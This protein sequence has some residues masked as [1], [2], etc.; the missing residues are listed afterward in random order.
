MCLWL[1]WFLL[2]LRLIFVLQ[3]WSLSWN[4]L[5]VSTAAGLYSVLNSVCVL[6]CTRCFILISLES[7]D[8][9]GLSLHLQLSLAEMYCI[10][11]PFGVFEFCNVPWDSLASA[12]VSIASVV[13]RHQI[14]FT[15]QNYFQ[16]LHVLFGISHYFQ[17][18]SLLII[19]LILSE[20]GS[21]TI[22]CSNTQWIMK[23]Q[24]QGSKL[25]HFS[26]T[27]SISAR[28][29]TIKSEHF[30]IKSNSFISAPEQFQAASMKIIHTS[31]L[32]ERVKRQNFQ[33]INHTSECH[34]MKE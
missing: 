4:L 22:V 30:E 3:M 31:T 1:E 23:R 24:C 33:E 15:L 28:H 26:Q 32:N 17:R 8:F 13:I 19:S 12:L 5:L 25:F 21:T 10:A 6:K 14:T 11:L 18:I 20:S 7:L 9:K 29:F 34:R 16:I 2:I 27:A